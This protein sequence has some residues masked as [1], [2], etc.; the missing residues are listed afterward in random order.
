[1]S[2]DNDQKPEKDPKETIPC[3]HSPGPKKAPFEAREGE[4][5]RGRGE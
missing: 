5:S 4:D 3:P 1:M 2:F